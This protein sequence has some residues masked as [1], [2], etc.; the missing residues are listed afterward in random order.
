MALRVVFAEDLEG[1]L[2]MG[3]SAKEARMRLRLAGQAALASL[4]RGEPV[5]LDG[6]ISGAGFERPTRVAGAVRLERSRAE[7]TYDLSV[8]ESTTS[9][10]GTKQWLSAD[11]YAGLTTLVLELVRD[12]AVTGRATLRLDPRGPRQGGFAGVKLRWI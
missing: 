8:L 12:G 2:R 7:L 1:A 11:P 4:L 5:P 6:E 9:L 10:R 3:A